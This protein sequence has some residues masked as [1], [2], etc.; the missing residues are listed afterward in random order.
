[1]VLDVVPFEDFHKFKAV[2]GESDD[3]IPIEAEPEARWVMLV[4]GIMVPP[5]DI[6][7]FWRESD[8]PDA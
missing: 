4:P 7:S 1:M 2:G 8:E 6:D 5:P 3:A